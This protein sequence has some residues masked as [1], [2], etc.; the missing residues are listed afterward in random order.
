MLS[1]GMATLGEI[2]GAVD[3]FREAGGSDIQLFHC[4]S[5]YPAPPE[6]CNLAAINAIAEATGCAVGWSDHSRDPRVVSRAIKKFG[7]F[8]AK[9]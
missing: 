9:H 5:G 7:K 8:S 2:Q 1:T 4:V 3:A 6:D